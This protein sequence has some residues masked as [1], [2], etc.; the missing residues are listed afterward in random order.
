MAHTRGVD[1]KIVEFIN[2]W[3]KFEG[4][5]GRQRAQFAMN[6]FG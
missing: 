5:W 2:C 1:G 4:A 3:R 6:K